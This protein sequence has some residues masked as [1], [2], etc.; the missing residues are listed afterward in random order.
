MNDADVIYRNRIVA[1]NLPLVTWTVKRL[2][3]LSVVQA[4]GMDDAMQ[5]G[6]IGLMRAVVGWESPRGIQFSTYAT[7][8]IHRCVMDAAHNQGLVRVPRSARAKGAKD[9]IKDC[10]FH[11]DHCSQ[12]V[13]V[14][15]GDD[16]HEFE[17]E[18]AAPADTEAEDRDEARAREE[19][20]AWALR[21]GGPLTDVQVD[22]VRMR[23]FDDLCLSEAGLLLCVTKERVRQIQKVAVERLR[24]ALKA[25]RA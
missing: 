12:F 18:P 19:E 14:P 13:R 20:V 4:L 23:Y 10:A 8:C 3:H 21:D 7:W 25:R 24:V 1:Q 5:E 9:A 16:G 2:W 22:V 6:T 11:A 15:V 17:W